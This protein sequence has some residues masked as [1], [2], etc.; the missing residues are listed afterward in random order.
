MPF[1]ISWS[2]QA[3]GFWRSLSGPALLK[4]L[5][6]VYFTFGTIGIV[7]TPASA[8]TPRFLLAWVFTG[9]GSA[10]W[11]WAFVRH[12]RALVLVVAAQVVG[13]WLMGLFAAAPPSAPTGAGRSPQAVVA[14]CVASLLLGYAFFIDFI[15]KEG[16]NHFRLRTEVALASQAHR[17]LVPPLTVR[18]E[19]LEVVG[20]SVASSEVGGDLVDAVRLSAAHL[21]YVADVCGHG[22]SAGTVMSLTKGAV[23]ARALSGVAPGGLLADLNRVLL[24]LGGPASFVT[25]AGVVIGEPHLGR[26]QVML[27]GH[28]PILHR[29]AA[30]G[31]VDQWAS[32]HVPLGLLEEAGYA[33]R[34]ID[35]EPGD[36]LAVITDGLSE[37]AD[38]GDRELGIDGVVRILA[39]HGTEP[40]PALEERIFAAAR[41]HGPQLDDQT[42]LLLRFR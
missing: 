24:D 17:R 23:R 37:V 35:V 19:S 29:R 28:L 9:L 7:A 36:V 31:D 27:A 10:G 26:A 14:V 12:R 25:L 8:P 18:T 39:E 13:F 32:E 1:G 41:R 20:R 2:P 16:V 40:L 34:E 3:S 33:A 42:L 30:S 5:A 11:V 22:I 6:A 15:L 21:F 4:L 38:A